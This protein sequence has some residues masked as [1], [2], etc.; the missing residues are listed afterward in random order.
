MKTKKP[1]RFAL[2]LIAILLVA[3]TVFWFARPAGVKFDE[4]RA[5]RAID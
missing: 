3:F 4:A 5:I 2:A 1:I